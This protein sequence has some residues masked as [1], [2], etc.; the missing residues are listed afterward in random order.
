[1][2]PECMAREWGAGV[3]ASKTHGGY[4]IGKVRGRRCRPRTFFVFAFI[5]RLPDVTETQAETIVERD[6]AG[7]DRN[8]ESAPRIRRIFLFH[9]RIP[10]SCGRNG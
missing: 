1:M 2:A 10:P 7:Y 3:Q 8:R 5:T 4:Y 6:G 9:A